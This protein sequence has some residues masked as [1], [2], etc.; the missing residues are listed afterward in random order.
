MAAG[1]V[2]P[3]GDGQFVTEARVS[4]G[5]VPFHESN[6]YA[7]SGIFPWLARHPS[8]ESLNLAIT[9]IFMVWLGISVDYF[10]APT[11]TSMTI[12][13]LFFVWYGLAWLIRTLSFK[14]LSFFSRSADLIF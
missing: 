14:R 13:A 7:E 10:E 1:R 3:S 5:Q 2:Q 8:F 11:M 12:E 9:A 4:V 6:F